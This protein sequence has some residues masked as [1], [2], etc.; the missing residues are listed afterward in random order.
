VD[1]AGGDAAEANLRRAVAVAQEQQSRPFELRAAAD[2]AALRTRLTR[3]GRPARR[4]K[5]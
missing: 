3:R 5:R 1:G 4:A 2:L